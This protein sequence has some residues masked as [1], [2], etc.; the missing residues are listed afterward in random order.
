MLVFLCNTVQAANE[1]VGASLSLS[2]EFCITDSPNKTCDIKL[3]LNWHTD[4]PYTVCIMSDNES[5]TT[6]CADSPNINS[7]SIMV[8]TEKDIQFV[9]MDKETH[10]TLADAKLHVT[11]TAEPQV[12]RRYRNPWSL[13]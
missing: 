8:S 12:R 1:A 9:M 3:V 11:P 7:L 2:P 5:L 13:F 10:Q 4:T 6:W